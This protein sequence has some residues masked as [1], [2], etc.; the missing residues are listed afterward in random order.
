MIL[1]VGA[2]GQLGSGVVH[3]LRAR[4]RPVRAM[5]RGPADDLAST[6]PELIE[7]DLTRDA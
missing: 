6:G 3:A 2:T 5:V 4:G 1:V 7:A